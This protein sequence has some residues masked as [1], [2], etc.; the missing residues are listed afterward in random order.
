MQINKKGQISLEFT[1]ILLVFIVMSLL[2]TIKPGLYGLDKSAKTASASLAH[3]GMSKLKT[4]I[5][6]L[7]LSDVNSSKIVY[8]KSPAGIWKVDN[9]AD[10]ITFNGNGYTI[11]TTLDTNINAIDTSYPTNMSIIA[12]TLTKRDGYVEIKFQ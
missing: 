3:A 1:I 12:I 5:E 11:T 7:D 4:N 2:A 8:I 9:D 6:L 10:T